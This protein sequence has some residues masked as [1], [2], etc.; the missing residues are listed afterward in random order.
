LRTVCQL[1]NSRPR[2]QSV[3]STVPVFKRYIKDVGV[4]TVPPVPGS[5]PVFLTR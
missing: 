1:R 4:V 5:N 3:K 2:G